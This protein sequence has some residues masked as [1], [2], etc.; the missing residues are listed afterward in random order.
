LPYPFWRE[1]V[2][3]D[4]GCTAFAFEDT[5]AELQHLLESQ[6]ENDDELARESVPADEIGP[7][8]IARFVVND[9]SP[10]PINTY[11]RFFSRG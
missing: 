7:T 6:P 11:D 2:D 8:S 4:D 9:R 10:S 3:V 5:A 1:V